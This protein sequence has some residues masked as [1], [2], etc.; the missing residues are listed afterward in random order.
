VVIAPDPAAANDCVFGEL[1][2][3]VVLPKFPQTA[4]RLLAESRLLSGWSSPRIRRRRVRVSSPS[5]RAC[6]VV[7][8]VW[9]RGSEIT[10][11]LF[12]QARARRANWAPHPA[13]HKSR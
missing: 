2:G 8:S 9:G 5:R 10:P 7:V 11:G 6:S 13:L 12:L 1:A 3:L 4:T